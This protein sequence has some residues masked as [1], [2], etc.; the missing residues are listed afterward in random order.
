MHKGSSKYNGEV[1]MWRYFSEYWID[2]R[3][4]ETFVQYLDHSA[5]TAG[6]ES[7][8]V[9]GKLKKQSTTNLFNV[10]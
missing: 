10:H 6:F 8:V 9:G 2:L 4:D 5:T 1:L 7:C 3:S